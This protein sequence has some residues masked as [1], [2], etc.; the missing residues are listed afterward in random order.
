MWHG[1]ACIKFDRRFTDWKRRWIAA[2][3]GNAM[4]DRKLNS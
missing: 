4:R 1:M 3:F 2:L